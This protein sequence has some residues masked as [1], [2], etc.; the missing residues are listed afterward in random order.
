LPL[1]VLS[2]LAG[3][4]LLILFAGFNYALH[5]DSGPVFLALGKLDVPSVEVPRTPTAG[6]RKAAVTAYPVGGRD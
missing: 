3:V 1:W 5:S 2:A 6:C 4:L